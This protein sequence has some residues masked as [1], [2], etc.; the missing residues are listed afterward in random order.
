MNMYLAG[1]DPSPFERQQIVRKELR[2]LILESFMQVNAKSVQML[3]YYESYLLDSG[4]FS[5]LAGTAKK[6][7][8]KQYVDGFADY[9]N[10]Y[11]VKLY[12]ELDIDPFIGYDEVK[13]I[14]KYLF[15]KTRV[16]PIPVWHKSRGIADFKQM[17]RE[18]E[19]VALGG[20]VIKEFS[21][22]EV[23]YF[24]QFIKYA[25]EQGAKIHGLGFT[26]LKML[27]VCHFDSVDSTAW[28]SG[29]QF[30]Y[31]YKFNGKTMT[32]INR[33]EGKRL[34]YKKAAVNNFVEWV[35]FQKYAKSH[36]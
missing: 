14:R 32:K 28:L 13:R 10:L 34:N 30:G 4:A 18:Y 8:L 11:K 6:T 20:Y 1:Q 23:K 7:D 27:P 36:L 24:P 5:M 19:Y 25:H 33:P 31:I 3:P 22:N 12:F 15:D 35:K 9:I 17:C 2:P 21:R 26:S 29:V 16:R